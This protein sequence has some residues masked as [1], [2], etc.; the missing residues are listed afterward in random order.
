M[1]LGIYILAELKI[2][3]FLECFT[4]LL[5]FKSKL[6]NLIFSPSRNSTKGRNVQNR[7]T[8]FFI[9][10]ILALSL[11]LSFLDYFDGKNRK[12]FPNSLLTFQKHKISTA[13]FRVDCVLGILIF[14]SSPYFCSRSNRTWKELRILKS[15][16]WSR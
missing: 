2:L 8:C 12:K 9:S 3:Y 5:H 7:F 6:T 15:H 14:P 11:S 1:W 16:R 10:G 4:L 13:G